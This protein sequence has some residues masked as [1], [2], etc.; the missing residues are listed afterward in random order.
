[1]KQPPKPGSRQG[2]WIA[3]SV[4][5]VLGFFAVPISSYLSVRQKAVEESKAAKKIAAQKDAAPSGWNE[6]PKPGVFWRWCEEKHNCPKPSNSFAELTAQMEVWCRD[7][8]CDLYIQ[9]NWK[10]ADGRVIGWTNDTG[11]GSSGDRVILTFSSFEE[12]AET[13]SITDFRF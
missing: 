11:K 5:L 6:T 10:D 1:M 3:I 7:T 2:V 4:V 13:I 12:T 8:P 9:A